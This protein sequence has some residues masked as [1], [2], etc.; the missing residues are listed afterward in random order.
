MDSLRLDLG[1]GAKQRAGFVGVDRFRLPGVHVIADLDARHLPFVDNSFGLI[2]AFHSLEHAGDLTNVMR[3]LWR[4][5]VPGA[6]IVIGA[7]YSTTH[8]N[9]AN[10]YHRQVFNEHTP[11]F[12]TSVAECA[13]DT[14][15]WRE[16][17]FPAVWG[18]SET[19]HS[20]PG[21]DFRCIRM[22]FFYFAEYWG[23]SPAEQRRQ[24]KRSINVCE[25]ILYHIVAVKSP[26]DEDVTKIT[27]RLYMPPE[28]EDR[29][30]AAIAA[31]RWWRWPR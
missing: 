14:W 19:D 15:E 5:A 6:Q 13:V 31:R 28:L 20:K 11:R 4:V 27:S 7:P 21:F 29:R 30:K 24:R 16:P 10:P 1:C 3:E 2:V 25:Q 12:W 8:L 18:L 22:E 23:L 17:P 26:G 9:M